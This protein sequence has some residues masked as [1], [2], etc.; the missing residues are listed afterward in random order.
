MKKILILSLAILAGA[1]TVSAANLSDNLISSAFTDFAGMQNPTN[2]FNLME[3][4]RFRQEEYN[5]FKDM[6][7]QKEEKNKKIELQNEYKQ[8]TKVP[9]TN[10]NVNFINENGQIKIM[11][12]Q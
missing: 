12:I 7:Q 8:E 10:Q 3:Q 11:P 9:P 5:E 6:K 1:L 2:Q 4:Q